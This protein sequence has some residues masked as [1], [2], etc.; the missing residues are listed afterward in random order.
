MS[1]HR[2]ERNNLELTAETDLTRWPPAIRAALPKPSGAR[3]YRCALQVNPHH[4]AETFR[5]QP[6]SGDENSYMQ[7]LVEKAVELHIQVLALTDHNHVG[8]TDGLRSLAR[9]HDI[10]VIPGFEL[11]SSEGVHVLCLYP[12]ETPVAT[13]E[14]FLGEFGIRDTV[15]SSNLS[16]MTFS[17][18]LHTVQQTQRGI[19]I[20][21]HITQNNGLLVCLQGQARIKAWQDENLFAVQIPGKVDELP[22]DKRDIVRNIN[23][24][25]HRDPPRAPGLAIAAINAKDVAEPNDLA[26]LGAT[27]WIKMSEVS[28]DGLRQ[29]FLDPESRI[30][31]NSDPVPEAHTE[32]VALSWQGGFLDGAAIHFNENLNVLIGGRGTGKSTIVESLRY[33]L[34]LEPLGDDARR[35]HDGIVFNVLKSGTKISLLVRAPG[36]PGKSI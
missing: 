7:A 19:A 13:L 5:G 35:A 17:E 9:G 4:Y 24:D 22:Q 11:A 21:A 34:G 16:N 18:I 27:C 29:A 10:H 14:R 2:D 23:P 15:P 30:R 20:A 6:S 36:R 12:L 3:F 8:A 32:F 31:L 33:V 26:D 28:I 1:C 25:Y